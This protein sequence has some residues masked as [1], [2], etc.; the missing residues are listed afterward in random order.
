LNWEN[1]KVR[2][3]IYSMMEFWIKKGIDGFRM[4]VI[5]VISKPPDFSDVS[6]S[7]PGARYQPSG[8]LVNNGP[9]FLEFMTEMKQRV[10]AKHDLFTVGETHRVTPDLAK[11]YLGT[12]KGQH[13]FVGILTQ[14]PK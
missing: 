8:D 12:R 2:D 11:I 14:F 5:N 6:I 7:K 13:Y 3:E 4:D 1:P 10:L 9:R